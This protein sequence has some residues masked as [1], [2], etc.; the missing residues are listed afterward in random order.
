MDDAGYWF[1]PVA[2]SHRSDA[3]R[4]FLLPPYD[5]YTVACADRG[6][7]IDPSELSAAGYGIGANII[8]GG[9]IAGTWK[10]KVEKDKVRISTHLLN[11]N[12][13][14]PGKAL[15]AA[16]DRYG[17]FLQRKTAFG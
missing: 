10:R 11:N 17:K 7:A 14:A 9:R 6:A 3:R 1:P 15:A 2:G 12:S 16:A 4:V 13:A 5:E 8:V